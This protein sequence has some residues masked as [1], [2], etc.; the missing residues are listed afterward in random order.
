MLDRGLLKLMAA[1]VRVPYADTKPMIACQNTTRHDA[2]IAAIIGGTVYA[3][4]AERVDRIKHSC[5]AGGA[6]TYLKARFPRV[7]FPELDCAYAPYREPHHHLAHAASAYYTSPFSQ[8]V[9]L[10]LDG[11]GP[12]QHGTNISTSLWLGTDDEIEHLDSIQE[13][14]I[15]YRSVGHYYAAVSYYLGFPFHDV[16]FTMS[17][18]PYGDAARYRSAMASLIWPTEDGLFDTDR[19]FIRFTTHTRFGSAFGWPDD[20]AWLATQRARCEALLGPM[21]GVEED[22][23]ERHMDLAAAAQERLEIIL[24]AI[25]RRLRAKA[26]GVTNLCY[27]GGVALN[28]VA[29]QRVLADAGFRAIH[30]QPAASDDGIALG[31]LLYRVYNGH[32]AR[33][34]STPSSVYLGPPYGRADLDA[35]LT[36]A[37][38]RVI[39]RRF[40]KRDLLEE[41]ARRI[42]SGEVIAW[43]QG[44]S[45]FGPRALGHRSVLAD[46]RNPAIA[47]AISDKF[48]HREWFRPFAPSVLESRLP[49]YFDTNASMRF[50]MRFMLAAV[51]ARPAARTAFAGALH[52]DGTARVH[53]VPDDGSIYAALL[54]AYDRQT[55][56][57]GLLNTSLNV[58]GAP[59]VETPRDALAVFLASRLDAL[60]MGPWLVQRMDQ[61]R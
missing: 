21:R 26:P 19:D 29:N 48:K 39:A 17:L 9:I 59:M 41:V 38:D 53:A 14:G 46:P 3:L 32:G 13:Q 50:P 54:A 37:C 27:A 61:D 42:A 12:H 52:V 33:V 55:G 35:A 23:Q 40:S 31:R 49:E 10:V 4:A 18:A 15:C 2:S 25:V 6:Y 5:D 20:P 57:P 16:S 28:C 45:E 51:T 11:M 22:L 44:R 58:P 7:S 60:V 8:A 56:V 24:A 34:R 1:H 43:V 30:I 47:T 36:E